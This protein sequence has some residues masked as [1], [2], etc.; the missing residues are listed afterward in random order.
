M[1]KCLVLL[2]S[3]ILLASLSLAVAEED[4]TLIS[5]IDDCSYIYCLLPDGSAQITEINT[6]FIDYEL[7]IP[8]MLYDCPVTSIAKDLQYYG[9]EF[10]RLVIPDSVTDIEANP[11]TWLSSLREISV[12]PDHPVFASIDGALYSKAD[13]R[14]ISVPL[15]YPDSDFVIPDG[16]LEIGEGAF[17]G[18]ENI[19]T[20]EIPNSV[21]SI[22]KAAFT[23]CMSLSGFRLSPDHPSYAVIDGV[24]YNKAEKELLC[25]PAG[26]TYTSFSIPEGIV[27]IAPRAFESY[28]S[29]G[30]SE[31]ILPESLTY[32]GESAFS[33][34]DIHHIRIPAGVREIGDSAFSNC[35]Y[36]ES[37]LFESGIERLGDYAFFNCSALMN[38]NLPEGLTSLGEAAFIGCDSLAS[39][40]IP[41][42]LEVIVNNP[43]TG[44]ESL[45]EVR[46][47]PESDY[48]ASIDGVLFN[49]QEKKLVYYPQASA[50]HSYAIPEG[51][52]A[53]GSDAFSSVQLYEI[54]LPESLECIEDYAF[55]SCYNLQRI[56]IPA[57]VNSIGS[58]AFA[59]TFPDFIVER[60]SYAAEYLKEIGFNYEYTD[61]NDW[62]N[63]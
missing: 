3:L 18:C 30:P 61:A 37:V 36:L 26:L 4:A 31:I 10:S 1:K 57:G 16:I 24:L 58:M 46:V 52:R 44:C 50:S 35:P 11:F 22:D 59:A 29:S 34:C 15:A 54:E 20:I 62:L 19:K 7:V 33:C 9:S 43:F 21:A 13:K 32:I 53:I 8:D 51:I 39:I 38:I 60:N 42:S 47:S 25:Y 27:G 2:L 23:E 55:T 48:F 14:L 12:S 56:N 40:T 41:A 45:T 17:Y 49:K 6:G 63:S 5:F 28:Y